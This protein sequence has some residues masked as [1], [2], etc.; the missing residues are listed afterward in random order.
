MIYSLGSNGAGQL[1]IGHTEDAH[2][3]TLTNFPDAV[4]EV[5]SIA[6]GGNHTLVLLE[7]GKAYATG[8]NIDGRCGISLE[9]CHYKPAF[10][11]FEAINPAQNVK[12]KLCA[13]TW[14]ASCYVSEQNE[15]Y[16]CGT[17]NRGELGLGETTASAAT[18]QLIPNFPPPGLEVLALAACMSHV[19]A[20]L[21]N[22]EI[23]GWGN[24]RKGQLGQPGMICWS[25]RK[26]A[27]IPFDAVN[28]VCGRDFSYVVGP[29]DGG[30]HVFLGSDKWALGAHALEPLP[31]WK[32]IGASWGSIFVLL[33]SGKLLSWGR[34]DHGQLGPADLPHLQ[35]IAI[36]SEHALALTGS[37][38]VLAWGWGEHGN[39]GKP[40]ESNGDVK[41]R[42]N[43]LTVRAKCKAIGAGCATSWIVCVDDGEP[44]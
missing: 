29:P 25:P 42:S 20:V 33:Q 30:Q 2:V 18:V 6:A 19:I 24:G 28:A 16:T 44:A 10:T 43:D 11:S 27:N 26:I 32:Q 37:G 9:S 23:Y 39:C 8:E 12:W 21:S 31:P 40:T 38:Q 3:P 13:A 41:K 36:G 15:I 35:E 34:N 7:S 17:G 14:E 22:G 5:R 4:S 1:A